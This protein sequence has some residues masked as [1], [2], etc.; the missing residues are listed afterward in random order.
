MTEWQEKQLAEQ[1]FHL[2]ML[3]AIKFPIRWKNWLVFSSKKSCFLQV[4]RT[5]SIKAFSPFKR[6]SS[7][8]GEAVMAS[9][10]L[11]S[12]HALIWPSMV[13][14]KF[15]N[16]PYKGHSW[17][18]EKETKDS[19]SYL[20]VLWCVFL[21]FDMQ[22][23]IHNLISANTSFI[24]KTIH[25]LTQYLIFLFVTS[26]IKK[27]TPHRLVDCSKDG[28]H[29]YIIKAI[30]WVIKWIWPGKKITFKIIMMSGFNGDN[31]TFY[32]KT[33]MSF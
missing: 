33:H 22:L 8:A 11:L 20:W 1:Y 7:L 30:H 14:C 15:R 16:I 18:P 21:C 27:S 13:C 23:C 19:A 32:L 25:F 17:T 28:A 4:N 29:Y 24:M 3:S 2:W 31:H 9:Q 10:H 26:L 5:V 6:L 12:I